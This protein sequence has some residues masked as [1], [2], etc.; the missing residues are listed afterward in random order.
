MTATLIDNEGQAAAGHREQDSVQPAI[1]ARE[2]SRRLR[3]LRKQ[4]RE[5]AAP[6]RSAG[7]A[8]PHESPQILLAGSFGSRII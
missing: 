8:R 5:G 1:S 2:R 6:N 3:L 7:I 4:P